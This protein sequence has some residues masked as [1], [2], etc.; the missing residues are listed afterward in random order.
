MRLLPDYE[1]FT[2]HFWIT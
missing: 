1:M 2:V